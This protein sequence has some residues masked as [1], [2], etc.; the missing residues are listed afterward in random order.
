LQEA[1]THRWIEFNNQYWIN[2]VTADCDD[3]DWEDKLSVLSLYGLPEPLCC[4]IS[5]EK[6]TAHVVWVYDQPIRR[7]DPEQRALHEQIRR[8]LILGLGADPAFQNRLQKNPWHRRT[9]PVILLPGVHPVPA[10][11]E[12]YVASAHPLTY[13]TRMGRELR[14][15][16]PDELY[17]PLAAY[18]AE[19]GMVL[20]P[21]CALRPRP[22]AVTRSRAASPGNAP[23]GSRLF[24][25]VR[26][27]A[28]HMKTADPDRIHAVA[29][30]LARQLGSP[31]SDRDIASI[32]SS[33]ARF[34]RE[35]WYGP[36]DG[37]GLEASCGTGKPRSINARVMTREAKAAGEIGRWR[38]LDLTTRRAEAGK[39]SGRLRRERNFSRIES[40]YESL[41]ANGG[42]VTQKAVAAS[43]EVSLSTVK[44][45]WEQLRRGQTV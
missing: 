28:Y 12:A 30:R 26:K 27:Y 11:Y 41:R 19:A 15:V 4:V 24:D 44:R 17:L 2:T 23:H 18:A 35:R 1:I 45:G 33:V 6:G 16:S 38:N 13:V 31:A 21:G 10:V 34:M 9:Q 22:T 42:P 37:Q 20:E 43:A 40:A 29:V 39:R 14:A 32:A 7:A 36:L 3:A 8:G 25:A 5:P